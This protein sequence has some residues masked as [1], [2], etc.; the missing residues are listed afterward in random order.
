M[1][2]VPHIVYYLTR[3][4]VKLLEVIKIDFELN[5]KEPIYLQIMNYI[6]RK[7]I[8][9]E[10]GMGEKL[11]SVR[12]LASELTVNPNTIQRVYSELENEGLI[13]TKRGLGKYVT[14]DI[15]IVKKLKRESAEEVLNTFLKFMKE[16]GISKEEVVELINNKYEKVN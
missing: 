14:E 10:L 2:S 11:L 7:I 3:T 8:S 15:A 16:L 12:E 6:K 13:F 5:N 1:E 9:G 4:V